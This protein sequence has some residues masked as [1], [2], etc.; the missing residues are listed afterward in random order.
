MSAEDLGR[1]LLFSGLLIAGVG[2]VLMLGSHVPG[3]NRLPGN[4]TIEGEAVTIYIPIVTCL[5]FS[6]VL[7]LV[8]NF[9]VRR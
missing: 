6:L 5:L 9:L 7:T 1:V 4:I 2:V 3:L 8:L